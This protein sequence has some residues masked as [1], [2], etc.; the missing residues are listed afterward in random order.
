[1]SEHYIDAMGDICPIPLLKV[2]KKLEEIKPGD[3]IIL[4]TDHSCAAPN[5]VED[6]KKKQIK[7]TAR[8]IDNGIWQIVIKP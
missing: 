6:M 3:I 1:M 5:I 4:E 7:A 2:R 8:E